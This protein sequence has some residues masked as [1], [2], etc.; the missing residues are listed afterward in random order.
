[1]GES[2]IVLLP[3]QRDVLQNLTELKLDGFKREIEE[4]IV[5]PVYSKI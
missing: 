4:Q 1:M 2:N 5:M 3:E